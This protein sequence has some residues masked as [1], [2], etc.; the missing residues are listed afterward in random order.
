MVSLVGGLGGALERGGEGVVERLNRR[1]VSV[2]RK[3]KKKL[4]RK[5]G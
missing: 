2:L 1:R 5:S 3:K 4:S